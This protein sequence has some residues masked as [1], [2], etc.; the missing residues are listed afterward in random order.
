MPSKPVPSVNFQDVLRQTVKDGVELLRKKDY[1]D[2]DETAMV[3]QPLANHQAAKIWVNNL[4]GGYALSQP[5]RITV[6]S[7]LSESTWF[8][9][10]KD[11]TLAVL[12]ADPILNREP[13]DEPIADFSRNMTAVLKQLN[14]ENVEDYDDVIVVQPFA[15]G[16]A[17]IG[18][19][20][21]PDET[22]RI[23]PKVSFE[24]ARNTYVLPYKNHTIDIYS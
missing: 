10:E 16:Q 5:D 11:N 2:D 20:M 7:N 14:M 15:S 6:E 8:L 17:L 3:Y 21:W 18:E 19:L 13:W 22:N 24:F 4:Q 12:D 1:S 23:N 9:P